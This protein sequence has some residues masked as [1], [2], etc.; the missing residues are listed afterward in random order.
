MRA[1]PAVNAA[2][3]TAQSLPDSTRPGEADVAAKLGELALDTSS[4]V[5]AWSALLSSE[6]RLAGASMLRLAFALLV[7]PAIALVICATLD[8]LLAALLQRW[9]QDWSSCIAIVLCFNLACLYGLL[10]AMRAWWRDLSLPR[11]RAALVQLF[12]RIA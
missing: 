7:V 3:Q 6:T 2:N 10:L 12:K 9:L 5:R 1:E 8:A 4:Y 11:S